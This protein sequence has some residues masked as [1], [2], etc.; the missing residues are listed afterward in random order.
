MIKKEAP[1][2]RYV[3]GKYRNKFY[4]LIRDTYGV[5]LPGS[6]FKGLSWWDYYY[7]GKL[8]A[9]VDTELYGNDAVNQ[10]FIE[11]RMG[12]IKLTDKLQEQD[13]AA[14]AYL[15]TTRKQYYDIVSLWFTMFTK[16]Q[17][18]YGV[19]YP[20]TKNLSYSE[21]LAMVTD[22]GFKELENITAY[23]WD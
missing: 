9:K 23:M 22:M 14:I 16:T 10:K 15:V 7:L 11:Y 3:H 4:K 17:Q 18:K 21:N 20:A 2:R 6:T 13:S 1:K 19:A 12:T 5:K 8:L